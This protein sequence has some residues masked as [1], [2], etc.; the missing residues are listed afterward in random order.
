MSLL[1][2]R[3]DSSFFSCSASPYFCLTTNLFLFLS[4]SIDFS[5]FPVSFLFFCSILFSCC[6]FNE[7]DDVTTLTSF[8]FCKIAKIVEYIYIHIALLQ[9]VHILCTFSSSMNSLQVNTPLLLLLWHF[10]QS[11]N[12][13]QVVISFFNFS[14]SV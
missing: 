13:L 8:F 11:L 10:L 6:C 12:T 9:A 5:I 1:S 4:F 7:D 3:S 14:S 2:T